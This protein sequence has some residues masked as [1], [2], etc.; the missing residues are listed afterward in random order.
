MKQVKKLNFAPLLTVMERIDDN[1]RHG[2][3]GNWEMGLGGYDH[4]YEIYYRGA[5]IG[6]VNYEFG[7]YELYDEDFIPREQ[8]PEFLAAIDARKF[9]DVGYHEGDDEMVSEARKQ[10][11]WAINFRNMHT[12][13]HGLFYGKDK[14]RVEEF[15]KEIEY[16]QTASDMEWDE[17][18]YAWESLYE[19]YPDIATMD[20][21]NY[22]DIVDLPG[23][24]EGIEDGDTIYRFVNQGTM[25]IY[26]ES[27]RKR[28]MKKIVKEAD[29]DN[30]TGDTPKIYVGTY[31]KYN[32][33]SL[34][35]KWVDLTEYDTYEDFLAAMHEL[36][37]DEDD[38]EFMVQDYENFPEKW[39]HEAGLPTEEE[40]NKINDYYMM[41]DSKK[42]A[43]EVFVNYTG[44]DSIEDFEEAYEGQFD[45][46]Q[47][48]GYYAIDTWGIPDDPESYIDYEAFG[49]DLTMDWHQGDPDE[50][51]YE[52]E[53]EDPEYYYDDESHEQQMPY[54]TDREVGEQYVDDVGI[55]NMGKD[56]LDNYFDYDEYG[57]VLLNNDFWEDAGY[58][59]RNI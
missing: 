29:G 25:D 11:M 1:G 27:T 17:Q 5:P 35:G 19:D 55:S 18:Q 44:L 51:D 58:V 8:I 4:G 34:D 33:G 37:S 38:P 12:A 49:R 9:K 13:V 53:P 14:K 54:D 41:D 20:E 56:F 57:R 39:Y 6:R 21:F 28:T 47:D 45:S 2:R 42:E 24:Y 31:A 48:F 36:H 59:F 52:G 26:N 50:E 10:I 46:P 15:A 43:Y 3:C 22:R 16:I 32:D 23:G 30:Y 40:F 7:E